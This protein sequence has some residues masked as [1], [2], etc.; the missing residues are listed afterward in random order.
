MKNT[1]HCE[2]TLNDFIVHFTRV[3]IMVC[4]L[5]LKKNS[6]IDFI[7]LLVFSTFAVKCR[8]EYK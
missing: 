1:W 4:E 5:Y 8:G 7:S 2:F 6:Y 3:N